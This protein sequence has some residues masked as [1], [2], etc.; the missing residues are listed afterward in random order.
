ME[1]DFNVSDMKALLDVRILT[2]LVRTQ[3][4]IL[5]AAVVDHQ[6]CDA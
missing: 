2:R 1:Q 6:S 3:P 5:T 4:L